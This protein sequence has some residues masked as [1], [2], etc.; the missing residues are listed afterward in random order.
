MS[1]Y[2]SGYDEIEQQNETQGRVAYAF[3]GKVS[4][5]M[6]ED[7]NE[8]HGSVHMNID[9]ESYFFMSVV[10]ASN[11]IAN[12]PLHKKEIKDIRYCGHVGCDLDLMVKY[13]K[14]EIMIDDYPTLGYRFNQLKQ[15]A[16]AQ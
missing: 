14:R 1:R 2:D 9:G 12:Q 4:K 15:I 10:M 7:G 8:P 3:R 16:E 11:F 13:I 5:G 6:D